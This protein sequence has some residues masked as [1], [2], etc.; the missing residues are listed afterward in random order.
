[1][2]EATRAATLEG[3]LQEIRDGAAM[4]R[5]ALPPPAPVAIMRRERELPPLQVGGAASQAAANVRE[6]RLFA[7]SPRW[8]KVLRL[9]GGN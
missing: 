8:G 9:H 4:Q 3:R 2:Q 7:G 6:G 5:L 1:M